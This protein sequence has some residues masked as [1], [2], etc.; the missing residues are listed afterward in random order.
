MSQDRQK[1][2]ATKRT[3]PHAR[4][5]RR[6]SGTPHDSTRY[7]ER[8]THES[9]RDAR[10]PARVATPSHNDIQRRPYRE[11]A[12]HQEVRGTRVD[13]SRQATSQART[14]R[15]PRDRS[16][17]T[18]ARAHK[19]AQL[20]ESRERRADEA[21]VR[22]ARRTR[23]EKAQV[24]IKIAIATVALLLVVAILQLPV[25][26]SPSADASQDAQDTRQPSANQISASVSDP[27]KVFRSAFDWSNLKSEGDRLSYV[28]DGKTLSRCGID[29]SEHSG[30]IDWKAV[31]DD[32]VD[33]A[34]IRLGYRATADGA[35][36]LDTHYKRNIKQAQAAGLDVGVYFYSQAANE[37]EAVEEA[38]YVCDTLGDLDLRYPI[39]FD[40]EPSA[41]G[42]DRISAL[43]NSERS[44]AAQA[45]CKQVASRGYRVI[46]YGSRSDLAS[47]S[48]KDFADY[49]FWY[50][51][52][53]DKPSLS[54]QMGIWQYS[55]KATV[56][57]ID[58]KVDLDL[59]LTAVLARGDEKDFDQ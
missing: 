45:F 5:G 34:Y 21:R 57:G 33:F 54:L 38:N 4:I 13:R 10:R 43:S 55:D 14:S 19:V 52:Y 9:G 35:I 53:A 56:D 3:A 7:R 11:T 22:N 58:E 15:G 37:D 59:D 40:M 12:S 32:G 8:L 27:N 28:V 31:A 6:P 23:R 16:G 51:E 49:G 2:R 30:D 1:K 42:T 47:Y 36:H 41:T 44:A 29:V 18:N 50:A 46:I 25:F 26:S 24:P 48:L 17:R 39:A 20:R